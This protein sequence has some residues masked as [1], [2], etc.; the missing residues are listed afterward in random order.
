MPP[1]NIT[2]TL[3]DIV[4]AGLSAR[5]AE[6]L[7]AQLELVAPGRF[8]FRIT[9]ESLDETSYTRIGEATVLAIDE[10]PAGA[11][12]L[13]DAALKLRTEEFYWKPLHLCVPVPPSRLKLD[14]QWAVHFHRMPADPRA[15]AQALGEAAPL[16]QIHREEIVS[17]ALVVLADDLNNLT[18]AVDPAKIVEPERIETSVL[19]ALDELNVLADANAFTALR[20]EL[21]RLKGLPVIN[22]PELD[23]VTPLVIEAENQ[24]RE[25]GG[26]ER[27]LSALHRLNGV[28]RLAVYQ[29]DDAA[30]VAR[31]LLSRLDA[32]EQRGL[33]AL[34]ERLRRTGINLCAALRP[35]VRAVLDGSVDDTVIER[36][37][38]HTDELYSLTRPFT[39]SPKTSVGSSAIRRIVVIE[40]DPDWRRQIVGML[41]AMLGHDAVKI[42]EGKTVA[43][44]QA[45]LKDSR[46]ALVLVDLGLPIKD[47][48][49]E[50]ALAAGLSLIKQFSGSDAHGARY[51]HRFV[52]LTAAENY[53]EAVRE[54]IGFGVSAADYLQKNPRTW[55]SELRSRVRLALQPRTP[56][57][58]RIEVFKRTGRIARVEGLEIVLDFPLWCLLAAFAESWRGMWNAPE[59]LARL[60]D[61]NYSL[62][63]ESRS[64]ETDKLDPA[65]RILLQLPHYTSDL[66]LRLEEAYIQATNAPPPEPIVS[67]E[68]ETGYRLNANAQ[69][70]EQVDSHFKTGRRPKV[71]VVEDDPDWA[72]E[73][74]EEL[75]RRG[76]E[77][78]HA[79]WIE[80]ASEV[81]EIDPPD[82]ISLDLE[83]PATHEEWLGKEAEARNTVQFLRLL[84]QEHTH[85]PVAILTAIPWRDSI[86]L[87]ILR[88]GVRVDDYLSKH[89]P[90]AVARLAA[91]LSRLWQEVLTETRILDW[92]TSTPIHPIVIDPQSN[93]LISVAGHPVRP[94]GKGYEIL[95][96]LSS[97]PNV[98]VSRSELL[99]VV[100]GDEE[101]SDE[102]PDDPDKALNSHLSRLRKTL[103]KATGGTIPGDQVVCGDRGVYWLRG[104]VQ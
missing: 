98:F 33:A 40:D 60:M 54:A 82:L 3:L 38:E 64:A 99:E 11:R 34:P 2:N 28:L 41:Q 56:R 15:L 91:S 75:R 8:N 94:T 45:L 35:L 9:G 95:R 18:R 90:G 57:L 80:E 96:A 14:D 102:G 36:L 85:L 27:A 5:R 47:D 19:N 48:D 24:L 13:L 68:R 10:K 73:I 69:L 25:A 58:P 1:E 6:L 88:Q 20:A 87:E 81:V 53:S 26:P 44:A 65:E 49:S 97:T 89:A 39:G 23:A 46:P 83:L 84:R 104:I 31:R 21:T 22:A 67:F 59:K 93:V 16:D 78:R 70:L 103:T 77:P 86:L 74:L 92:D 100:Y 30:D 12:A 55:E 17:S 62:N 42:E 4:V 52:I 32:L 63:P 37:G 29:P 50:V 7:R 61:R 79:R 72:R 76:F 66:R 51:Q 101:A 43:E 71:L